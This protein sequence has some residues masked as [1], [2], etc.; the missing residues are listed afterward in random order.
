MDVA[1]MLP[2]HMGP[3]GP[4]PAQLARQGGGNSPQRLKEVAAG[5]ESLFVSLLVKEMRQTLEPDTMFGQDHGEILGGLFDYTL[6]QHLSRA[7]AL[8]IG[9]M[10]EAQWS[11]RSAANYEG[12]V[13]PPAPLPGPTRTTRTS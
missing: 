9:R 13:P 11:A 3:L 8:G 7:G 4:D 2:M 1:A 5:F 10:L 6:G 12:A